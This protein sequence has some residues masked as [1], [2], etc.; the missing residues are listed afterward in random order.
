MSARAKHQE[1]SLDDVYTGE[2]KEKTS[3]WGWAVVMI[4]LIG[5]IAIIFSLPQDMLLAL[6]EFMD[7]ISPF[8]TLF[9]Y[10]LLLGLGLHHFVTSRKKPENENQ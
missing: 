9:F 1:F 4:I 2:P 3:W 7:R 10:I 5:P 6:S 8:T